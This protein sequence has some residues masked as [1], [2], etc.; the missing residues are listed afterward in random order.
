VAWQT[1]LQIRP[2]RDIL[3][4]VRSPILVF[5][6]LLNTGMN[7][8]IFNAVSERRQMDNNVIQKL[9]DNCL[10]RDK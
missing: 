6:I 3:R 5:L 4:E 2:I 7:I 8:F 1:L 10:V 9:L